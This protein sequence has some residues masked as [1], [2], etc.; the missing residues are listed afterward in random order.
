MQN[1]NPPIYIVVP[2]RVF[3]SDQLDSTHSPVFHQIEGLA[4]DDEIT[5]SDLKG[6]LNHFAKEFF[7]KKILKF[8]THTPTM[9]KYYVVKK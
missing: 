6:T 2:G 7:G 9:K 4:V 3:R 1:N 5:F 8:E